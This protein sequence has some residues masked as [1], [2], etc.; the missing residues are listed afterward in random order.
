MKK[1]IIIS[2][3]LTL[4]FYGEINAQ[5]LSSSP[6]SR[7]GV[8]ELY[9]Q[10]NGRQIA[11]G[12]TGIGDYDPFHISKINPASLASLKPN[13]II[14]E[15]GIFHKISDYSDGID[16]QTNNISSFKHIMAGFRITPWWHTS[17]GI[18]P[19]SGIG[20]AIETTD[21]VSVNEYTTYSTNLY[22][23]KGGITQA[24][25]GNSFTFLKHFSVGVNI[26]YNFGSFDRINSSIINDSLYTSITTNS[27]RNL[28]KKFNYDLGF[29]Y[30]DTILKDTYNNI[31][32]FSV[33][34]IFSN[35]YQINSIETKYVTRSL[36]V[37]NRNFSDSIFFDTVS[38]SSIKMPRTIGGGFSVTLYDKLNL[39]GDYVINDWS[40]SSVFGES[41]YAK[42]TFIGLGAEYVISPLSTNYYKTIRYRVGAF[43]YNSYYLFNNQQNT[44]QALT[45]GLG[46]PVRKVLL[47]L[48]FVVGRS[49]SIDFGLQEN[50][51]EFNFNLSFY[52]IWFV[53]RK[54]L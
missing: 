24:F 9:F 4:I 51:Y 11:M 7:Y 45:F 33:G 2:L 13:N 34:G 25:W 17:I 14:F 8:G 32:H 27:T 40:Q 16:Y 15:I 18:I 30:A 41:N 5:K 38:T 23:G 46:I 37:Y 31:L 42:S 21:S 49:G 39:T 22:E 35:N 20:Y 12:N 6:F 26:N 3:V 10:G 50:F 52:D 48:G 54:F 29:L 28:F 1:V 47:N 43:Q 44:T 53:K 36:R 19:F